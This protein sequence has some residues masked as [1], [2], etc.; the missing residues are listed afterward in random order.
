MNEAQKPLEI[1]NDPNEAMESVS[2]GISE[3]PDLSS[4]LET[5]ESAATSPEEISILTV[6]QKRRTRLL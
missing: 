4:P 6:R 2:T 5:P 3:T 1:L